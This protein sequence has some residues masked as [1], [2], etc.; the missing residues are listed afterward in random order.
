M[1]W[2]H[3]YV[4]LNMI[5]RKFIFISNFNVITCKCNGDKSLEINNCL[6][7]NSW[8]NQLFYQKVWHLVL[9]LYPQIWF[10]WRDYYHLSAKGWKHLVT[11]ASFWKSLKETLLLSHY[12][13]W[14]YTKT[15]GPFQYLQQL[16]LKQWLFGNWILM[17]GEI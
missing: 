16:R 15:N 5:G 2:P 7:S 1:W 4:I 9:T 11:L 13:H 10:E 3:G 6:Q 12:L 17:P 14:I 8:I